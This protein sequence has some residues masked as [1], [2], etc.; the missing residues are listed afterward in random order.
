[1]AKSK[2]VDLR[3]EQENQDADLANGSQEVELVREPGVEDRGLEGLSGQLRQLVGVL[4]RG[5]DSNLEKIRRLFR[6]SPE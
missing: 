1:M 3:E 5:R 2:L 6:P 4:T